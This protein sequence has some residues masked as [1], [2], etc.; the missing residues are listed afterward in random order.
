MTMITQ[1]PFST[2]NQP[3]RLSL[4]NQMQQDY[5][6]F[7]AI[8]SDETLNFVSDNEPQS[9]QTVTITLRTARNNVNGASLMQENGGCEYPMHR[10]HSQG[11]FDFWQT[12][13]MITETFCY[14]FQIL[15]VNATPYYYNKRGI[16]KDIDHHYNFRLIPGFK[17]PDWAKGAVMYQIYV[18]R[19]YNG[20]QT[21]DVVSNEYAYLGK[22]A[23]RI[24]DWYQDVAVEDIC[25]F[26][27]GDLAGVME[28]MAYL[29][30]LGVDAIY[31][32]PIFV[33]PSNHKYDIQDYDYID[34]HYGVIIH[35]GGSPLNLDSFRN[36]NATMYIQRTTDRTNLEASNQLMIKLIQTAHQNGI[37]VILDGVFNHC[38]AF[39][40]WMDREGFYYQAGYPTGAYREIDSPYNGYFKW[41]DKDWPNNDCYDSW[42]GHDNHP[43]L[44]Y[45]NSE[46]LYH[47]I[48]DIAVKWVSP[49]FNAD[50][51]RLDVA[52]DL[53]YSKEFNHCFWRDFRAVVKKANPNAIILAE[54]YGDP[55]DWLAGDQWDSIMNYDAF[56]EP[57]TWFL[58]GMEKHSEGYRG[59]QFCNA[60]SFE[61]AMRYH[62]SRL[63]VPS[64][65]TSM[66]Q[67]SNHDHSRF[68]TRTNMTVGRLHTMS[69]RAAD[70]GVNRGIM[71]EAVVMQMTWPG[72]PTIYYGDEAGLT[73]WTDP[74]NRRTYP[75]GREDETL[76]AFHKE[77]IRIR[78]KYDCLKAGSLEYLFNDYGIISYGRWNHRN[79]IA[80]ILNNN[81]IEQELNIP[82]WKINI[83][84]NAQMTK[85]ISTHMTGYCTE[86]VSFPVRDGM[87][88]ITLAPYSSMVLA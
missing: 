36:K 30:D 4:Y 44:Y 71:M 17:T 61:G 87:L 26:Y 14:Y 78:Q 66:N 28:K 63:T 81:S 43:K 33:S 77:M 59:D 40:K 52:A 60:M 47:Y 85:L 41:Y 37:K 82:V 39:N 49:P 70:A 80:V 67:L 62:M 86:Q 69:A 18:D 24:E 79:G 5:L 25:N 46:S 16:F 21:N 6:H 75:W 58:T 29:R 35:D 74:D 8:F 7:S 73:G 50:G 3:A 65:Q 2:L 11:L 54:H 57:L 83:D 53:G 56:M 45:E 20:D 34:P 1:I 88:S 31:L 48:L 55:G 51:W 32:N 27:G 22:S 38:G 19:F 9:G 68:L 13:V 23:K 10:S 72:A 84:P 15:K 42:W 64:L 12:D 76:L